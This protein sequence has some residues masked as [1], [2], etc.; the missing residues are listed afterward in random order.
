MK[1]NLYFIIVSCLSC[2]TLS[3]VK[4]QTVTVTWPFDLGT[5]NQVATFSE[6]AAAYF[7]ANTTALGSNLSYKEA[8]VYLDTTYTS[9]QPLVQSSVPG[10][11]DKVSFNLTLAS[12]KSFSP[13]KISF[14][15]RRMVTNG[16]LMNVVWK[17]SES[18]A[19]TLARA[20]IPRR[21]SATSE[22]LGVNS[23]SYDLTALNIPATTKDCSLEIF[24]Y[25]LGN[26][27][28]IGL[29][30]IEI[31]GTIKSANS[32]DSRIIKPEIT[33]IQYFSIDG[34]QISSPIKGVNLVRTSYRDGSVSVSKILIGNR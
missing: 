15:C 1:R 28:Q 10:D 24:L 32:L 18:K 20:V 12:G 7:T 27:K 26:T 30:K 6:G 34:K 9:I 31:E 19:D 11:I 16:G 23:V 13:T 8:K 17:S 2:L 21:N 4:A 33:G 22:P 5:A 14:N 25:N 3:L 29:S